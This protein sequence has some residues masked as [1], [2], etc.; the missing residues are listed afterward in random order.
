MSLHSDDGKESWT[1]LKRVRNPWGVVPV[2]AGG[3]ALSGQSREYMDR[4]LAQVKAPKPKSRRHHYVPRSYL[5]Q[6]SSDGKRVWCLD[7]VTG[8][9]N[10]LGV[11]DVGVQEDFH[12]VVGPDGG[13]HDRVE[14]MFAVVDNEM[15]RMQRLFNQLEDPDELTFDDLIGLGVS[16]AIQRMRTAQQR[17]LLNQHNAWLVAQ[18]SEDFVS[19]DDPADPH[20][21]AGIHTETIF[22]SMWE[23]A[24]V[25]TTRQIEVWDDPQGRFWTCD[26]PV[27]VPFTRN[28]QPSVVAAPLII[29]PISPR[30]AI[31]L[32]NDP[33]GEK[34]VLLTAT[35]KMVG[36]VRQGVLQGRERMIIAD[37]G[38]QSRL[39]RTMKFRRRTQVRLRCSQRTPEGDYVEPPGC[40]VEMSYAFADRPDIVL[41]GQGLHSP[42]PKMLNYL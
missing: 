33:Q 30:R 38:Q 42:A 41:C 37:D 23:A 5:R 40:C 32:S 18:S 11:A 7:T 31:A 8:S 22:R 24:D 20:R 2:T 25:M 4:L 16:V 1:L 26:A 28:V 9:V 13:P 3:Q 19:I 34:A 12:R 6:W 15:R 29:W 14:L 17:R 39:P 35:G 21:A 10:R 36:A 27:L